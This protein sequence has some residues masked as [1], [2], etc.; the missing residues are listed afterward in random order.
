MPERKLLELLEQLHE[1]L[2]RTQSVDE[3]GR[4]LLA[5][6]SADIRKFLDPA[7]ENPESLLERVQAAIDHFEVK[8][9]AITAALSQMLTT[10]SNAGI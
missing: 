2:A 4:E 10:L 8:H 1:E 7:Q 6:I 9:P 3:E 5:H